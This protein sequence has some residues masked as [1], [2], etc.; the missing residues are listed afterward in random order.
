M[1]QEFLKHPCWLKIETA[2][3]ARLETLQRELEHA[4]CQGDTIK[5]ARIAG[6]IELL[7]WVIGLPGAIDTQEKAR[8]NK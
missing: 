6:A 4:A 1:W 5:A 2:L 7:R 3:K 8:H